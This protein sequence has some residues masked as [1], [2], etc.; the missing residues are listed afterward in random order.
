MLNHFSIIMSS[1]FQSALEDYSIWSEDGSPQIQQFYRNGERE[2]PYTAWHENSQLWSRGFYRNGQLDGEY[3]SW[4][5]N[6][7]LSQREL[8]EWSRGRR[9]QTLVCRWTTLGSCI[10]STWEIRRG[11]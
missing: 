3:E 6:G 11:I 10:L 5:R 8:S 7:Q 4:H 2:G 9:I 1:E